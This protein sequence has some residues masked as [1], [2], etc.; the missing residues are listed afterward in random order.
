MATPNGRADEHRGLDLTI[1]GNSDPELLGIVDDL[2]DEDGWTTTLDVRMQLGE[3]VEVVKHSGVPQRLSWM[4]RYHWLERHAEG[5]SRWR[6]TAMG[7]AILD[8]PDLSKSVENAL[9]R[10]N[11][12]QR[13]RVAREIAESGMNGAPEV[14]TAL[15]REWQ[16]SMGR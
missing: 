9:D 13:L 16:R 14:K 12:A 15:R 6:L 7:H 11:P 3:N 4:V 2:A 10:L 5:K 1:W 8:N